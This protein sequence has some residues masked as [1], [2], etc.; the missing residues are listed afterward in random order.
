MISKDD[1]RYLAKISKIQIDEEE[2]EIYKSKLEEIV[3][4]LDK[5]DEI[6]E[7]DYADLSMSISIDNLRSD[8]P[9]KFNTNPI[10]TKYSKDGYIKGPKVV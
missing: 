9:R 5:L 1:I 7:D 4:F 2:S 3:T 6:K 10:A 8:S